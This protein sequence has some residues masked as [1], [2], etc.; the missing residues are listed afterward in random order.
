MN[1]STSTEFLHTMTS[2]DFVQ[3]T[4]IDG[5]YMQLLTDKGDVV[6]VLYD[7]K[8]CNHGKPLG[9]IEKL[10]EKDTYNVSMK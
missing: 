4:N 10:M 1:W 7:E 8:M 5:N 6:D 9:E 2:C 3:I